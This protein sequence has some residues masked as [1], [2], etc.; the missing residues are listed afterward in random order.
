MRTNYESALAIPL[1]SYD[2]QSF[3]SEADKAKLRT[4]RSVYL[5]EMMKI[6]KEI[7]KEVGK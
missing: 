5:D 4:L 3:L 6:M 1:L 7:E 2:D